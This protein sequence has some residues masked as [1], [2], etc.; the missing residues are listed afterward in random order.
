MGSMANSGAAN[1]AVG[2]ISSR[3]SAEDYLSIHNYIPFAVLYFFLNS[4]GLPVGLFYT[5]LFSPLLYLWLYLKGCRWLTAKF[6]LILSP[7]LLAHACL[8][9]PSPFYYARSLLL[10]WS[11]YITVYAFGWA[12]L[13][14]K[15]IERL[16][17]ELIVVN[18]FAAMAALILVPTPLSTYLWNSNFTALAEGVGYTRRLQLLTSEPSVYSSLMVPLLVFAVLRLLQKPGKRSFVY[19]ALI[20]VPMLLSQSFGALSICTAGLAA[21]LLPMFRRLLRKP[22]SLLVLGLIG[23]LMAG[24]LFVPNPI[25]QRVS[26]VI[27]GDDSSTQSRTVFSFILANAI[28]TSTSIWW[29]AGLGQA[30]LFDVS[31]LGIGFTVSVIPNAVAVTFA[32]FGIIGVLVRFAVEFYL[33]F[34]TRVYRNSFRLAMFVVAFIMQLTGSNVMDVQEYLIMFF[35]FAPLFP[36]LNPQNRVPSN[37]G[38]L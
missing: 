2:R 32:E 35:A 31:N 29:G 23:I 26:S 3:R 25:S 5:T 6:L 9:I 19:T 22:K 8:G 11:V 38:R 24:L 12:L 28:A 10:L 4:V 36:A 18:F 17:E 20:L 1:L 14:C 34:R 15:S 37:T 27:A 33:F 21:A 30:K 13:K 7:F 16:F